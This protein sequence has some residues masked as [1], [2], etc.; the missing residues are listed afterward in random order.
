MLST[1]RSDWEVANCDGANNYRV[2]ATESRE[3]I[4][5]DISLANATQIVDDHLM[6]NRIVKTLDE[7]AK[8]TISVQRAPR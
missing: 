6:V 3:I 7:R 4:A 2:V 1:D 5:R 8:T